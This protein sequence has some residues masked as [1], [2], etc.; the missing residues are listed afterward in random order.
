MTETTAL[1]SLAE[2]RGWIGA[3]VTEIGGSRVGQA[4]G[5]FLDSSSDEP[6]W[7]IVRLGRWRNTRLVAVPMRACA[8]APFGVWAALDGDDLRSAPVVD[9][10]RP[11]RREHELA[12]CSHFGIG[13][14]VGR[15]AEVAARPAGEATAAPAA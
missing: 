2:A 7:L 9:P 11:L 13:E 15:A 5:F 3:E 6:A 4:H 12:I 10:T 14:T 1:P 8:G